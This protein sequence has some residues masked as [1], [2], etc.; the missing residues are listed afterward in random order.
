MS[1]H[2]TVDLLEEI[3]VW[4]RIAG[5]DAMERVMR[6]NLSDTTSYDVFVATDG[7]RNQSEVAKV[8]GISQQHVSRLWTRWRTIGLL[9]DT[10][11]EPVPI[12]RPSAFGISRPPSPQKP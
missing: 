8:A 2:R 9:R 7:K 3:L 4:L 5:A 6:E 11:L 10:S 12:A 1:D